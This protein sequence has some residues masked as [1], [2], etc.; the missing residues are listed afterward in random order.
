MYLNSLSR[1]WSILLIHYKVFLKKIS[2]CVY[3]NWSGVFFWSVFTSFVI[4]NF[5][6]KLGYGRYI[7]ISIRHHWAEVSSHKLIE[8]L[9]GSHLNFRQQVLMAVSRKFIQN[10][11]SAVKDEKKCSWNLG[12]IFTKYLQVNLIFD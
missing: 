9:W 6:N 3:S 8:C 1:N 5:E 10:L 7:R 2:C 12:K 4:F 11:E